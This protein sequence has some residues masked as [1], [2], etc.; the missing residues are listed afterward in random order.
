MIIIYNYYH[1]NQAATPRIS[2]CNLF[3]LCCKC[4]LGKK[5]FNYF[6]FMVTVSVLTMFQPG[7]NDHFH[8][9]KKN[10]L[11]T[12]QSVIRITILK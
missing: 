9:S 8:P 4:E 12:M 3:L 10:V 11:P 6:Y 1:N 7:C 2:H 5:L